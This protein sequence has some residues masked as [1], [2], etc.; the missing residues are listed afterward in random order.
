MAQVW[1]T[2]DEKNKDNYFK[3]IRKDKVITAADY[4]E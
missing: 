4:L 2:L 3:L 1:R